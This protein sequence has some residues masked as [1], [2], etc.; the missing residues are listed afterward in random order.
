MKIKPIFLIMLIMMTICSFI[1]S[2]IFLP[3][4]PEIAQEFSISATQVQTML[5]FFLA[6]LA[7]M[8]LFYGPLSD[9]MGRRKLLIA[10]IILFIFASTAIIFA[11]HFSQILVLRLLQAIGGCAGLTLG[12]AIVSDVYGKENSG[13]VFLKIYPIVGMSPALAPLI[14]EWLSRFFGWESCFVFTTV[15]AI[16]LLFLVWRY[17]P[18]THLPKHHKPLSLAY[19]FKSGRRLILHRGF[20]HYTVSP[21][22]AYAAYF[23]YIAESPFMLQQQGMSRTALGMSYIPLSIAYVSGNVLARKIMKSRNLDQTLGLGYKFFLMGGLLTCTTLLIAPHSF[24]LSI[25]AV[26]IITLSNGFLM[27]LGT[28]GAVTSIPELSGT[29]SGLVGF[30]QL[31]TAA[32]AA[33]FIGPLS[34]HVPER[35]GIIFGVI[36]LVGFSLYWF[37]PPTKTK[38]LAI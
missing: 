29:A 11:R 30:L 31:T 4:L 7:I 20:L 16:V 25:A 38:A 2:D 37:Y 8:Q 9:S 24:M 14:G 28:A 18:E 5:S 19:V 34:Q 33:K 32:L 12:R 27:P 10:G 26:S 1:A 23:S 3:A 15:F 35:F 6:G 36:A 22:F 21:C 17:Q 13:Q